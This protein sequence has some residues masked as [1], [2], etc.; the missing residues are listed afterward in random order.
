MSNSPFTFQWTRPRNS[1][2]TPIRVRLRRQLWADGDNRRDEGLE[3]PEDVERF[4]D[5]SY[6]PDP[7]W[8]LLDLYRPKGLKGS[9]P[10]I[11][12]IHGGGYFYGTKET[13]QYYCMDL[14]RRGFAVV[15]FNYRLA[16]EW[17]FPAPLED[18]NRL[19]SW[20][21]EHAAEYSVDINNLFLVG[22]SAGA[23]IASQY[24]AAWGSN[25][26]DKLLGL[27]I[28]EIT[29]RALGLN[30][31]MYDLKRLALRKIPS[32][33]LMDYLGADPSHF[34]GELDVLSRIGSNYPPTHLTSSPND[35]LFEECAPM[36][37]YL[38][39]KGVEA[40]CQIYGTP[41]QEEVA[42][43][44][45]VNLRCPEGRQANDDQTEFFRNHM[46]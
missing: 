43:V 26:Y 33:M 18:T 27:E 1:G 22:D 6:G 3:I 35:F 8:H 12:S 11:V 20:L 39:A 42:H 9:L 7:K 17:R 37:E 29:I 19:L 36:A 40:V 46:V 16:P 15:N 13:Y 10:V 45:H 41:E 25:H 14:A 30:C 4:C 5:L 34:K 38:H 24:A 31:G 44:F 28:P 23:Q 32:L 21:K 2:K